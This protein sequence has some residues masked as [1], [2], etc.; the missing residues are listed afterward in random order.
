MQDVTIN[1]FEKLRMHRERL[2]AL[3]RAKKRE[4]LITQ[5]AFE[6]EERE[7]PFDSQY[8]KLGRELKLVEPQE[9][10]FHVIKH[11]IANC[12]YQRH[13]SFRLELKRVFELDRPTTSRYSGK[14][15]DSDRL[16]LW[17]GARMSD[18][19]PTLTEGVVADFCGRPRLPN[20]VELHNVPSQAALQCVAAAD[21]SHGFLMLCEVALGDNVR[22]V[23]EVPRDKA[24]VEADVEQNF[25]TSVGEKPKYSCAMCV[26]SNAPAKYVVMPGG[27]KFAVGDIQSAN[28]RANQEAEF[29]KTQ[30]ALDSFCVFQPDVRVLPRY[31]CQVHFEFAGRQRPQLR[32]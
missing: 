10:L 15:T 18:W 30:F 4:N 26:G 23:F 21:S 7:H 8:R 5:N 20:S 27:A 1:S 17:Y 9:K 12:H 32:G 2:A 11:A 19:A 13:K 6:R 3:Q 24:A 25:M 29:S 22:E 16:L 14:E 28:L 31:L